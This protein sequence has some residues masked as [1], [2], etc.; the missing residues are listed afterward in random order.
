MRTSALL[1]LA[2]SV[3]FVDSSEAQQ[4]RNG[5]IGTAAVTRGSSSCSGDINWCANSEAGWGQY[6]RFGG[7]VSNNL[8]VVIETTRFSKDLGEGVTQRDVYFTIGLN[9]YP[10]PSNNF[11]LSG[12]LG[13]GRSEI[14]DGAGFAEISGLAYS[15]GLGVDIG[16]K[17]D[18][19]ASL[20]P[21]V[22]YFST[23]GGRIN[24]DGFT[25]T[26][27]NSSLTQLGI[28]LTF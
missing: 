23:S 13:R 12:G 17:S 11:F 7:F 26:G 14:E 25:E 19:K 16:A 8:A 24:V 3:L 4:K 5:L 20:T 10:S 18:L 6:F 2:M 21:F 1:L 22:K 15:V 27:Y 28:G 9:L